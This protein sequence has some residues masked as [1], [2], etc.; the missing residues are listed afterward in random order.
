V[1]DRTVGADVTLDE[2]AFS[3]EGFVPDLVKLDIEGWEL[4]AL[5]GAA[6]L[7]AERRPHVVVETHSAELERECRD[8]LVVH[9]Y[10][11]QVVAPGR[12]LAEVRE[13]HNRWLVAEGHARA[14]P[15]APSEQGAPQPGTTNHGIG[16]DP[17][18]TREQELDIVSHEGGGKLPSQGWGAAL[19]PSA[20]VAG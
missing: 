4:K 6:R 15:P 17:S 14:L 13:G 16:T 3:R 20:A 1:T 12:W 11:P 8:L 5:R 2:T 9:G 19:R 7:L 10:A 18:Q